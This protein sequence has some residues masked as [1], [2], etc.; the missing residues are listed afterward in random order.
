M[1]TSERSL[2]INYELFS[3]TAEALSMH[4]EMILQPPLT[5]LVRYP[6]D[7]SY[8]ECNGQDKYTAECECCL[9]LVLSGKH[10]NSGRTLSQ[11]FHISP[12]VLLTGFFADSFGVITHRFQQN[13]SPKSR[14]ALLIGGLIAS[15]EYSPHGVRN[16]SNDYAEM[17]KLIQRLTNAHLKTESWIIKGPKTKLNTYTD[18]YF[19]T[20]KNLLIAIEPNNSSLISTDKFL[21]SHQLP[22]AML[23]WNNLVNLNHAS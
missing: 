7:F 4:P 1:S 2:P 12:N 14:V 17:V 16:Y 11:M 6:E 19:L 21:P 9:G 22:L 23:R 13:T 18:I 3:S 10:P 15:R 20:A 5:N 8:S